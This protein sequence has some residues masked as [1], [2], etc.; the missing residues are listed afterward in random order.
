MTQRPRNPGFRERVHSIVRTIPPGRVMSYSR[1]AYLA[2]SPGS[3]RAVGTIM[4]MNPCPGTG[5]G[6]TPCHR[7]VRSDGSP[8]GFTSPRG[9]GEKLRLLKSEGVRLE[10]GVIEKGFFL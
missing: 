8:G 5:P 10:K 1:V 7:V 4:S 9:P 3:A 2:G 6:A